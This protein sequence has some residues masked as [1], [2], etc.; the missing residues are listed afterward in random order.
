LSCVSTAGAIYCF[1]PLVGLWR[2]GCSCTAI[3]NTKDHIEDFLTLIESILAFVLLFVQGGPED[4]LAFHIPPSTLCQKIRSPWGVRSL[5]ILCPAIGPSRILISVYNHRTENH[6]SLYWS[7]IFV[8]ALLQFSSLTHH[9]VS[10]GHDSIAFACTR[11]WS[12]ARRG[13][14]KQGYNV[15]CKRSWRLNFSAPEGSAQWK[16]SCLSSKCC[17]NPLDLMNQPISH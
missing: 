7:S 15:C 10:T 11:H 9:S 8:G 14:R 13:I 5:G 4:A 6:S 12:Y 16:E 1:I 2:S 17:H 3:L